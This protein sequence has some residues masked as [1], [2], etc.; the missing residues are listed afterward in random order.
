[1]RRTL[2][3]PS[4]AISSNK[5]SA[6]LAEVLS[7]SIRTA[8]RGER[9]SRAMLLLPSRMGRQHTPEPPPV[10]IFPFQGLKVRDA[11]A[12]DGGHVSPRILHLVSKHVR[13][14]A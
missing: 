4:C 10:E 5:R 1:M 11:P 7:A 8:R 6:I 12:C 14:G 2:A 3:S 13:P 9:G